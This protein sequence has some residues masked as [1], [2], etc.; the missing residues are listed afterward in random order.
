MLGLFAFFYALLHFTVYFVL[1]QELDL[2][3]VFADIAKRPTSR[4]AS[5]RCCC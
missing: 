3:S 5:P 1:D 4:S 2:A